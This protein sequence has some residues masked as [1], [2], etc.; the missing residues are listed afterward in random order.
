MPELNEVESTRAYNSTSRVRM[1]RCQPYLDMLYQLAGAGVPLHDLMKQVRK[2]YIAAALRL[3]R[4]NRCR[5]A[6][7]IGIHRNSLARHW[8]KEEEY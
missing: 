8:N 1:I 7:L 5:A 6:K 3:K 2:D 4:G